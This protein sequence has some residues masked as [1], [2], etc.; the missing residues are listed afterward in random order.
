MILL[1][2]SMKLVK[3]FYELY[4]NN[5]TI[6]NSIDNG[7]IASKSIVELGER[8]RKNKEGKKCCL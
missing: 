7:Y 6:S 8:Q 4:K 2:S 5:R 1:I 3:I